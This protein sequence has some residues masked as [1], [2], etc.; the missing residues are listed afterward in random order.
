MLLIAFVLGAG[1]LARFSGSV[2][3]V[4]VKIFTQHT[5][6]IWRFDNIPRGY[7]TAIRD[8]ADVATCVFFC[9]GSEYKHLTRFHL[10]QTFGLHSIRRDNQSHSIRSR[11][12]SS[13]C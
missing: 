8:K 11:L 3:S 4:L 1:L 13:V 9:R 10:Q 2:T 5:W 12:V 7:W 6:H